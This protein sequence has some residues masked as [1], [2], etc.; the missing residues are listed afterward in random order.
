MCVVLYGYDH[1]HIF[2][3]MACENKLQLQLQLQLFILVFIS[4]ILYKQCICI[5]LLCTD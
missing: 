1:F 3:L 4:C 5:L 2:G